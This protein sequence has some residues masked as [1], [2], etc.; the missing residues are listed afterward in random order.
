MRR[1]SVA[2]D[3]LR[4]ATLVFLAVL[5]F[6]PSTG[7]RGHAEWWGWRPS[8]VFFPAF[9]FVA[10]AGLA[11]QTRRG[12]PWARLVRRVVALVAIGLAMN[13]VLG[14][15]PLR[16]PGVL[17]RIALVGVVG[18][19]V[20]RM[21]RRQWGAVL[22][23]AVVVTFAWGLA[24]AAASDDCRGERPTDRPACGTFEW[25][26][27]AAF[28]AD[29]VYWHGAR[30]HDPEGLASSLGALG[31]FLA[32]FAAAA[33]LERARDRSPVDRAGLLLALAAGWLALTPAAAELAPFGK[34]LWTP[35]YVTVNTAA[36][37]FAW[38][39]LV[40]AFDH[41]MASR[42]VERVRR[43]VAW[44]FEAVGRNTLILW[45]GMFLLDHH[46]GT[47]GPWWYLPLLGAGWLT[48]AGAL[49]AARW[50]VRL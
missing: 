3:V 48:V 25:I 21:L 12:F 30:G 28:G 1:R 31:S 2:L 15:G 32:G 22:G 46:V 8:D 24:L 50:H 47:S 37:L 26:D 5:V 39:A 7:W 45:V 9:L 41:E 35:S 14:S 42:S 36:A 16:V 44:P 27:V 34:R 11:F 4:G 19:V 43:V 6:V 49:H 40:L 29:H 17:Q 23:A 33:L 10:G 38:A 13:A 18:A 20:A